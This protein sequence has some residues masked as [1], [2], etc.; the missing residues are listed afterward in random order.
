MR[1]IAITAFAA[2]YGCDVTNALSEAAHAGFTINTHDDPLE[3]GREAVG[4]SYALEIA[5]VDPSLVYLTGEGELAAISE[6]T[7]ERVCGSQ[8]RAEFAWLAIDAEKTIASAW[9]EAQEAA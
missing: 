9:R 2:A 4:L 8:C 7:W 6:E 3:D 1:Q 5:A